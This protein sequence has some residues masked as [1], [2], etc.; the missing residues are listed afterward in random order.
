MAFSSKN[1]AYLHLRTIN[2]EF[3]KWYDKG[4]RVDKQNAIDYAT[5]FIYEL[6][7]Y[8]HKQNTKKERNEKG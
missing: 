1:S 5:L 2:Q 7:R 3:Q 6:D 4:C 8:K